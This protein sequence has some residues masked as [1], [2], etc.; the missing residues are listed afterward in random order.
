MVR[1]LQELVIRILF[2]KPYYAIYQARDISYFAEIIKEAVG[3]FEK[4]VSSWEMYNLEY[5]LS[6][7]VIKL[8]DLTDDN[9]DLQD[10]CLDI[11]D[12]IYQRR[13]LTDSAITKLIEG[14]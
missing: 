8:I 12:Q 14:V 13:I 10:C 1:R 3:S 7:V 9:K 4:G 2:R 11:I 6:R 5:K